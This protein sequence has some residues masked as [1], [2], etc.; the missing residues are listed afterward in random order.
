M[1]GRHKN[2]SVWVLT[3]QLTSV[4]QPFR[5]NVVA[6]VHFYSQSKKSM[7]AFFVEFSGPLTQREFNALVK[8]L[9]HYRYSRLVV[10]MRCP[11]DIKMETP[12]NSCK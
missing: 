8:R 4:S 10:N 6:V 7:K 9:K 11:Y 3:Q 1:S 5:E 12:T 2:I